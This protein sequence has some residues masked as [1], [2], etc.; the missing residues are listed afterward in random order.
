MA[1]CHNKLF[2]FP[3][4]YERPPPLCRGRRSSQEQQIE[5]SVVAVDI[6][7]MARCGIPRGRTPRAVWAFIVF[8]LTAKE[9]GG[10]KKTP[11]RLYDIVFLLLWFFFSSSVVCVFLA[12]DRLLGAKFNISFHNDDLRPRRQHVHHG[13]S[14][15]ITT[16]GS[17]HGISRDT[18]GIHQIISFYFL[19]AVGWFCFSSLSACVGETGCQVLKSSW[20]K[21][22]GKALK[23]THHVFYLFTYLFIYCCF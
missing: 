11:T 15:L 2:L 18:V 16:A 7:K 20:T 13:W 14:R 10:G 22:S 6:S 5:V 8:I 23:A 12:L 3:S 9:G 1:E 4:T 21:P 17:S 19:K